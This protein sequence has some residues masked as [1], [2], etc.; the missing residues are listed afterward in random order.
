[1]YENDIV[2]S[3]QKFM[4][5]S[6]DQFGA[7]GLQCE[8]IKFNAFA[9]NLNDVCIDDFDNVQANNGRYRFLDPGVWRNCYIPFANSAGVYFF[10]NDE[11]EIVYVG[12][13]DRSLGNRVGAHVGAY[14]NGGFPNLE[15][16]TATYVI[17][18]P[19]LKAGFLACAYEAFLLNEFQFQYNQMG[20]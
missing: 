4:R 8:S 20:N 15:F 9:L 11:H 13:S 16:P 3:L 7:F 5:Q 14:V 12:K 17:V 19:F 1:M 10:L 6:L 18:V 2:P